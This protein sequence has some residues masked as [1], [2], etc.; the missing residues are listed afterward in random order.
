M[1][2]FVSDEYEE[3]GSERLTNLINE[4]LNAHKDVEEKVTSLLEFI[5]ELVA[6]VAEECLMVSPEFHIGVHISGEA[7]EIHILGPYS[8]T[9]SFA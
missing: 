4:W 9:D 6:N 3:N 5:R 1:Y 8:N 7:N 2:V